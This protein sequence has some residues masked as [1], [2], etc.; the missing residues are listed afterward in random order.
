M[1]KEIKMPVCPYCGKEM[2][3]ARYRGY[4]ESFSYWECECEDNILKE[5]TTNEWNGSYA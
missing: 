4:Y 5:K 2:V 3:V 1:T